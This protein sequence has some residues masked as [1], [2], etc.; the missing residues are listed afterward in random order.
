MILAFWLWACSDEAS[1][2]S[3]DPSSAAEAT[4]AEA[5]SAEK[6]D[7]PRVPATTAGRMAASHV[8]VT[9]T[10]AMRADASVQRTREEARAR[11]EQARAR[12][13]AGEDFAKVAKE[14]SDDKTKSRGG[15]L[16]NFNSGTM[17]P[18]FE[19]AV[20]GLAVGEVSAVVESPF[21]FHVIRR[22]MM[23]Q[24]HCAQIMVGYGGA[25]RPIEGVTRARDEARARIEAAL[26]EIQGGAD[27]NATV[28]KYS[29]GPAK[30][31]NGDLGWFSRRQLMP[32][33]DEP[34]FDLDIGATTAIIE[35]P[36]GFHLL[37]RLE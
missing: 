32:Q 12:I 11:A 3:P 6:S 9:A 13:V 22:D 28:R 33:L 10:G 17:V 23:S 1:P 37:K 2:P 25:E 18:V 16:G 8:L 27:W 24:I 14:M 34:A 35:T 7:A 4:P 5:K 19:E 21:G 15:R 29:D 31:D 26:A 36:T 30:E 20:L